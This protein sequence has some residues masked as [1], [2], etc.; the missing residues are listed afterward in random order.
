MRWDNTFF[1]PLL[2]PLFS[3][4]LLIYL[5][6]GPQTLA[7][8]VSVSWVLGQRPEAL[9]MAAKQSFGYLHKKS[10]LW[11]KFLMSPRTTLSLLI[12]SFRTCFEFLWQVLDNCKHKL[13]IIKMQI[14][15]LPPLTPILRTLHCL[16]EQ[17]QFL[18]LG[19]AALLSRTSLWL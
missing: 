18:F 14:T 12:K 7:L 17:I 8:P 13:Q 19:A 2:S 9:C 6:D 11:S 10:I 3:L 1:L 15:S 5:W 16:T 4:Y